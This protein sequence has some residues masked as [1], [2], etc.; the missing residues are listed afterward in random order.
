MIQISEFIEELKNSS[1]YKL[2]FQYPTVVMIMISGSR[3]LDTQEILHEDSDIDIV[4]IVDSDENFSVYELNKYLIYKGVKVHWYYE[5][6]NQF[7]N[8]LPSDFKCKNRA[9]RANGALQF[10]YIQDKYI[11][12]RNEE[13]KEIIDNLIK[14]KDKIALKGLDLLYKL[15]KDYID[16]ILQNNTVKEIH[17]SKILGHL[18]LASYWLQKETPNWGLIKHLKRIRYDGISEEEKVQCI[19]RLKV[20]KQYFEK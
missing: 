6:L 9:L 19:D 5:S 18:C 12:Y 20:F 7:Q 13:Y 16:E 3:V 17:Y 4:V 8:I 15:E 14:E 10:S 1:Y 2:L 11:I